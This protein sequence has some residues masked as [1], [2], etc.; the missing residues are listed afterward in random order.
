MVVGAGER[1]D[2][3][4]RRMSVE[5]KP[6]RVGDRLYGFCGGAFGRD[7][8]RDKRVEAVGNDWVVAR[9]DGGDVVFY[10]GDPDDLTEYRE[11]EVDA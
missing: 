4:T 3:H 7:A 11:P 8:F 9:E 5:K 1:A 6:L 10:A 2:R